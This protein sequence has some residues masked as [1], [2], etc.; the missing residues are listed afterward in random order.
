VHN[1]NSSGLGPGDGVIAKA[2]SLLTEEFEE[3]V[4]I[5]KQ[6]SIGEDRVKCVQNLLLAVFLRLLDNH[7]AILFSQNKI[8]WSQRI[9]RSCRR[10]AENSN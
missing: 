3:D 1:Y 5:T 2:R 9:H 7:F 8:V 6:I 4:D 10:I